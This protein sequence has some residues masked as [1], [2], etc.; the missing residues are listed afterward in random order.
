MK[1][2]ICF[3]SSLMVAAAM[4]ATICACSSDDPKQDYNPLIDEP[5][6]GQ[7][8]PNEPT[9]QSGYTEQYRPQIHFTPAENW[10]RLSLIPAHDLRPPA[11]LTAGPRAGLIPGP[12]KRNSRI[13]NMAILA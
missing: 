7:P 2:S 13:R 5:K 11:A 3:F 12:W 1:K 6:E 10:M 8:Q 9:K 4:V